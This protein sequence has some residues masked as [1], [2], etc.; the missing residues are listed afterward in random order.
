MTIAENVELCRQ[1]ANPAPATRAKNAK[2]GDPSFLG[3]YDAFL[4]LFVPRSVPPS[5]ALFPR[6]IRLVRIN[7]VDKNQVLLEAKGAREVWDAGEGEVEMGE[8]EEEE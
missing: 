3:R 6:S 7:S 4:H 5:Y 1:W 2:G 8:G